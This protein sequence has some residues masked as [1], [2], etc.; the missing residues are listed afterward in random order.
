MQRNYDV[1]IVG[2]GGAGLSAAIAAHDAGA[3]CILLEADTHLGGATANSGGVF[4]AA[5]TSVQRTH[6]VIGDTPEAMVEYIMTLNQWKT[7]PDLV[8]HYANEAGPVLEWLI[9]IGADF[10]GGHLVCSGVESVARGHACAG[11]GAGIGEPLINAVGARGIETVLDCRV[12]SLIFDEGNV[13]GVR[14][15]GMALYAP[16]VIITTGGIGNSPDMLKRLYPSS[17]HEGWT[18]AVHRDNPF[19]LGDGLTMA[20]NI[21]A[22]IVGFDTG[23]V[24]PTS[25]FWKALEPW[26]PPWIMVVNKEGRRFMS[27]LSPYS[28][29]GYL[30]NEQ[31]ERRVWAIFD[32]KALVDASADTSYLD[33]YK[34][35]MNI[36]TW[37]ESTIRDQVAK[38][39]VKQAA[40]LEELA[41]ITGIDPIA[42][43]Q[44]VKVY[45]DDAKRGKD[46]HFYKK[47]PILCPIASG[48]FYA[49]EI[50]AA[51][52]GNTSVGLNIDESTRVLDTHGCPIPGLY[53]AGEVLG[54]WQGPRYAGGGLA[55]GGAIVFGLLAGQVAAR[56]AQSVAAL[57]A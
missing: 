38:G 10:P 49:V 54:C 1:I 9:S 44:T 55:V 42:L 37:E 2:G 14:A 8:T 53:A 26:L 16:C 34:N 25:G 15:Q 4:Y 27:E 18:W 43:A 40:T 22:E 3:S 13:V 47:A 57:A 21:G 46:T 29:C 5:N 11:G 19:I 31:T 33:P 6:G 20:E 45:N 50:R 12:E 39:R 17:W 36:P 51:I 52:I 7:R 41:R 28:A 23:L 32:D 30:I 35:G 56:E 48:P 24:L